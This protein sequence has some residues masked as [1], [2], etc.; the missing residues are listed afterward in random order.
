[1]GAGFIFLIIAVVLLITVY[2]TVTFVSWR[3]NQILFRKYYDDLLNR[4]KM[5]DEENESK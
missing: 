2:R 4:M 3:G 1:M 5:N